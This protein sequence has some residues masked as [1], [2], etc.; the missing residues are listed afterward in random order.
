M[1]I[2]QPPIHPYWVIPGKF[3]AGPYPGQ[4]IYDPDPARKLRHLLNLGA[5]RFFD[6]TAP[7]ERMPYQSILE[8]EAAALGVT[9][10][11]QNFPIPDF[12][13]P[14]NA[15]MTA[16]LDAIDAALAA[17]QVVYVHC[18]GGIG[19]TGITVG[20]HLARHGLSGK[21]ALE[22][23]A[24]LRRGLPNAWMRSPESDEQWAMVSSWKPGE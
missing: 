17:G 24:E 15:F 23:L 13:T 19:R 12:S 22:R 21:Q 11:Y 1:S 10:Q 5:T 14:S 6:L 8:E 7:G 20:C 9:V 18:M 2:N 4:S 16:I 3:L